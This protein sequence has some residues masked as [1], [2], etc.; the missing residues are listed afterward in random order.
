MREKAAGTG[1]ILYDFGISSFHYERSGRGFGFARNEKLDMRLDGSGISAY[2]VVNGYD[3]ARLADIFYRLGEERW[4]RRIASAICRARETK[5]IEGTAEL[6]E[7]VM[8]AVPR[9]RGGRRHGTQDIHPATR[10]FQAIRIHV[11]DELGAIKRSLADAWKLLVSGGR[12]IAIA[13]HSLEDRAVK[14]SFRALSKGCTCGA[15]PDECSCDGRP[16]VNI[17]TKKPVVPQSDEVA[18]NRRAR[19]AKMRV[20]ERI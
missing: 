6:A 19:S 5:R 12:I 16:V 3:S 15:Y 10:V 2:D 18:F 20:C 14:E 11:N 1:Y 17:L 9:P 13:F 7:I 8:R 4:S